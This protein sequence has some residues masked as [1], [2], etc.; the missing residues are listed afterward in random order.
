MKNCSWVEINFKLSYGLEHQII[1]IEVNLL[2]FRS[3]NT[4]S[5][6]HIGG[7]CHW[8]AMNDATAVNHISIYCEAR[9]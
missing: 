7:P 2:S 6:M 5:G 4:P 1:C 3:A 9:F 8:K